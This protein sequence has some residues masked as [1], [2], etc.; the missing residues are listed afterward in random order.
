[1]LRT[2]PCSTVSARWVSIGYRMT[3]ARPFS[4]ETLGA[5]WGC[6]SEKIRQ[7]CRAGEIASFRLGKLY[8]IPAYEVERFECQNIDSS[9]TEDNTASPTE[10]P[11]DEL[12]LARMI[13]DGPK[14]S[15]VKSG[16]GSTGQP[17]NG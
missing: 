17:R 2:E 14:L 16:A 4:P 7:M 3:H 6:S 13:G 1:M 8:R 5:H 15:L 11:A 10:L 12:R 9:N